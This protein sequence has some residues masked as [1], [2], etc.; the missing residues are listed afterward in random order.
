MT[1]AIDWTQVPLPDVEDADLAPYWEATRRGELVVRHCRAC[2]R[3]SWPPRGACPACSS[4]D[5]DWRPVAARGRLFTWTVVGHT[6]IAGF[7]AAVPFAVGVVE[8]DD[9]AG[10]RMVGRIT[11]EP[12]SL[13][14]G[15]RVQA[16][17][18]A[19]DE[20]VTLPA[21]RLVAP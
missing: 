21:W 17:F 5:L 10:V 18:V 16:E 11:S 19:A 14:I 15:A 12:D 7:K 1:T 4:L 9:A 2:D 20:R 13:E 6:S 8:I 3:L